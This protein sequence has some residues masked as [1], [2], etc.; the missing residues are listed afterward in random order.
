MT[1]ASH[2]QEL[3]RKHEHLSDIV[4]RE[5]RSPATDA[6]KISDLKKQKMKLKEEI[7]RLAQA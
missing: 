4:E 2:L 1:V 6:L 3:R 7:T 5:Q